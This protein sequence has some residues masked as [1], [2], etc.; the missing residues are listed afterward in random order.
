[1]ARAKALVDTTA[2]LHHTIWTIYIYIHEI[3]FPRPVYAV[4]C[5]VP[6]AAAAIV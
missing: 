5:L 3:T 6:Y 2:V 4:Y 1:M